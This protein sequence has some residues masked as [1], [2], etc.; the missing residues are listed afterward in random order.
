MVV[1]YYESSLFCFSDQ[2]A[3]IANTSS[4]HF[5]LLVHF[6][7]FPLLHRDLGDDGFL[8]QGSLMTRKSKA[9]SESIPYKYVVYSSK[10]EKYEFEFIYKLD[11]VND[12]TNR[13]LFVKSHLLNDEG[14]RKLD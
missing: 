12:I 14:K 8:V 13:C 6:T 5:V 4:T 3:T 1:I 11:S 9:V 10:K 2:L 7:D